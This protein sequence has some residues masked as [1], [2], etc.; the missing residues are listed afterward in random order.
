[1]I[2]LYLAR[3]GQT[4]ENKAQILQGH[5]PGRLTD[6]GKQQAALLGE[7]LKE[8]ALDAVVSSDLQRCRDTVT[9]ALAGR[10]LPWEQT[11]LLREIDWGSMTGILIKKVNFDQMPADVE[12]REQLYERAGKALAYLK[13][14]YDGKRLL[15]VGHG[16]IN[17]AI[18]AHIRGV[19]FQHIRSVPK[20]NNAE[21]RCFMLSDDQ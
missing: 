20:M 11:P 17:R 10:Q 21:L 1:M 4:E 5:L 19:T 15:V 13:Q 14:H 8:I 6:E 7:Q 12:S 16:L 3:H 18:E 2:T 9:I